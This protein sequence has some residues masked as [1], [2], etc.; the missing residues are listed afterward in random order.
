MQLPSSYFTTSLLVLGWIFRGCHAQ[1]T[2]YAPVDT[3]DIS[4]YDGRWFQMYTSFGFLFLELGG[5]CVTADYV[6]REDGLLSLVNQARPFPFFPRVLARTTGFIAPN[7]DSTAPQG[8]FTVDQQYVITLDP[9]DIEY[10]DP[11]NYW[12]IGLGPILNGEY[13]WAA[14]SDA[15][16]SVSFVL[17]RDV[18]TFREL[19]DDDATAVFESFGGFDSFFVNRPIMTSHFLCAGYP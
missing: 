9:D 2:T 4:A 14:V 1:D 18:A 15:E 7:P 6:I 16:R 5:N 17:A 12:I 10:E 11:G 13:Q 3:V 8:T 19:Y